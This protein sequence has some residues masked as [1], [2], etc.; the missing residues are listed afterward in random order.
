MPES[1]FWCFT[2]NNPTESDE[3]EVTDLLDNRAWT[4]YG[5]FGKE[6]SPSGTPHFQGFL[7]LDRSR[8]RSFLSHKV[9]R[10]AFFVRY[11]NST[12]EDARDYCKKEGDFEEF[13][14]FPVSQQGKRNDLAQFLDWGDEFIANHGRAPRDREIALAHPGHWLRYQRAADLFR[15]RAPA[16]QLQLGEPNEWQSELELRLLDPGDDRTIDFVVDPEGG[17]GK[18]WF[19]RYMATKYPEEV[20]ILGVTKKEDLAFMIDE[21]KSIFL[22]NVSRNQMEYLSYPLMEAMK[23]KL[24]IVGKYAS[25]LKTWDT[26]IHVVVL[27]NEPPDYTKLTPDRYNTINLI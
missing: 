13:G 27:G 2:L 3:Q 23:D 5:I 15:L 22:F 12:N 25:R 16:P 8:R 10:A 26:N 17:K 21:S 9:P 18:S 19:C 20:Q 14:T 7:I 1:R 11:A 24:V 6:I 4:A